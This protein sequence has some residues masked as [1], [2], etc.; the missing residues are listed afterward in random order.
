MFE[1][2]TLTKAAFIWS[3]TQLKLLILWNIITIKNIVLYLNIFLKSNLF[4]MQSWIFS[5]NYA[6]IYNIFNYFQC[7]KV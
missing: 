1:K 3:K 5:S 2:K 7:W 6:K 4:V